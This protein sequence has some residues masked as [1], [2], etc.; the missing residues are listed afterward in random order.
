MIQR[1]IELGEGYSDIYELM[2]LARSNKNRLQHLIM[3]HT[4]KNDRKLSSFVVVMQPTNPGDFQALYISLEGIP[5]H[6]F[7]P[8]KRAD[9]F[10]ELAKELDKEIIQFEVKPTEVFAEK[11]LYFQYL[12][13]ILRLNHYIPALR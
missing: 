5:N 10:Q 6:Q 9:L 1:F 8:N 13:G 3:L 12:I 11:E 7:Q 2:E 4:V